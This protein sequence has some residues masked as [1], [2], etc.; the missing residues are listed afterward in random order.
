MIRDSSE[1]DEDEPD[2]TSSG[3]CGRIQLSFFRKRTGE[4]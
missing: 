4:L 3:N 2:I 1:E